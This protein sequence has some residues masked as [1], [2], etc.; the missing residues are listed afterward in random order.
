MDTKI[1]IGQPTMYAQPM[2]EDNCQNQQVHPSCCHGCNCQKT[3]VYVPKQMSPDI[4]LSLPIV[5]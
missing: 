2:M 5:T 4:P 3:A 1:C